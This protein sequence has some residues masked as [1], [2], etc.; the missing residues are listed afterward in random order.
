MEDLEKKVVAGGNENKIVPVSS[1]PDPVL[2]SPVHVTDYTVLVK[3]STYERKTIWENLI[4]PGPSTT[5]L[6]A[7]K[8][9]QFCG[10][11]ETVLNT[12][13]R[14]KTWTTAL[15]PQSDGV[16]ESFN[17]TILNS[18]YL[19]VSSNQQGQ[20]KKMPF[21]CLLT[22]VTFTKPS[23]LSHPRCSSDVNFVCLQIFCLAG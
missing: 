19:M 2:A 1:F 4:I 6:R 7:R 15:H 5:A 21:S 17:R 13:H 18:L 14:Q 3:L 16:V 9:L 20:E 11:Q 8:K 23:A 10:S 12:R 22:G